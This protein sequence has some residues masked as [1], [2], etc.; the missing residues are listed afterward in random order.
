MPGA[1]LCFEVTNSE[2]AARASVVAEF[3]RQARQRG[4]RVAISG[5][6]RD[7]ILFDPIR[8][9]QVE[10]FKIDGG[11]V[12]DILRDPVALAKITAINQVRQQTLGTQKPPIPEGELALQKAGIVFLCYINWFLIVL[13]CISCQ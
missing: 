11:I 9:F 7:K 5:S 1:A 12:F 2:L 4:C 13:A 10:Y 3:A 6:G 8:G